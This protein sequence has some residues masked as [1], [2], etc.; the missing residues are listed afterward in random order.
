MK[1]LVEKENGLNSEEYLFVKAK[2]DFDPFPTY[3]FQQKILARNV[4]SDLKY[5]L[6]INIDSILKELIQEDKEFLMREYKVQKEL[7][8]KKAEEYL[9]QA[10]SNLRQDFVVKGNTN[11]VTESQNNI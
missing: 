3:T 10:D 11:I 4:L 2:E 5:V 6:T 1:Q 9:E 7:V 8:Y